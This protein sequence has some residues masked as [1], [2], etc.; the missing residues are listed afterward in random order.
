MQVIE[1][2]ALVEHTPRKMFELVR[3]VE[4][5]PQFLSWCASARVQSDDGSEQIAGLEISIAGVKQ[6][7]TTCNWL[8]APHGIDMRLLDGPFRRLDGSWRFTPIGER[9]CRIA[10]RLEFE[11]AN[12][13]LAMAFQRGFARVADR[14]VDDFS[15]RADQV[16]G[17]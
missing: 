3:D 6:R 17:G 1:R 5:Y 9:G 4:A 16:H 10:L 13:L 15:A 11:F 2:S 14:L 7:F 12:R 8:D